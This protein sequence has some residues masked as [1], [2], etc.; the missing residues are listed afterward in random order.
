[1]SIF[2]AYDIRGI[3]PTEL[4]EVLAERIG[5][6]FVQV[7]K[8]K[9]I[10]IGRDM[11]LSAPKISEAFI[12]GATKQG[13]NILDVGLVG[14]E[15]VYFASGSTSKVGII[16]T[17]S[18]N[19]KEWIGIKYY[20][21]DPN[22]D[23]G[24]VEKLAQSGKFESCD[25]VGS[26]K[27]LDAW[28]DYRKKVLSM[29]DIKSLKPI[30]IVVD[31][32]NGMGG[33]LFENVFKGLPIKIIPLYFEPD[34]SFPNH[35]PSPVESKNLVDIKKKVIEE[36]ADLGV[37]L[38][39]DGD[40]AFFIDDTGQKIDSSYII[41][42]ILKQMLSKHPK[43]KIVYNLTCSKIVSETIK[44]NGGVPIVERVGHFFMKKR[45]RREGAIFGGEDSGHYYYKDFW[46]AESSTLTALIVIEMLCKQG[47]AISNIIKPL[48]KYFKI[49]E[50][51][52]VVKD[53][54]KVLDRLEKIYSNGKIFKLD[55]VTSEF[56]DW[57]FN[58]R[59]SNTEPVIRLSLEANSEELLKE[60]AKEVEKLIKEC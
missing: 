23:M 21:L 32:G 7:F 39:G 13:A 5:R 30:K 10:I 4:D 40:R 34:G 53:K 46:Y 54:E 16:I 47:K 11:R 59:P 52:Y 45:M 26:V 58:V 50:T 20:G 1:M 42:L 56:K 36:K 8:L 55:G 44:A 57:W 33:L 19:P 49:E 43:S 27:K 14:S 29:V 6:A 51:N 25:K 24:S 2:K 28:P 60:K 35:P 3:Y 12:R 38:D 22:A 31:A 18:H 17:A 15:V 9:E 37:A 48:H 41:T